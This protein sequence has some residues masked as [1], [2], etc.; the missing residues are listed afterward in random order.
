MIFMN[1]YLSEFI[2]LVHSIPRL[3][4]IFKHA[5]ESSF[6]GNKSRIAL[7]DRSKLQSKL[8]RWMLSYIMVFT[9][10]RWHIYLAIFSKGIPSFKSDL[11]TL[12]YQ[13]HSDSQIKTIWR[14]ARASS[15]KEVG[16]STRWF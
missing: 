2:S 16:R 12:S 1:K 5:I 15:M 7:Q 13:L 8:P 14:I 4:K 10:T 3:V 9:H 6:R 11:V